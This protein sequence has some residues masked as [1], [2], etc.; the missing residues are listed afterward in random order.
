M[1]LLGEGV[2]YRVLLLY[3]TNML[4]TIMAVVFNWLGFGR[5][6]GVLFKGLVLIGLVC[7]SGVGRFFGVSGR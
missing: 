1:F 4:N 7:L 6:L 5:L 3:F 2:R